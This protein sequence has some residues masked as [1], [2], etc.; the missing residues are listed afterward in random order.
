[1]KKKKGGGGARQDESDENKL[2][3]S[4]ATLILILQH[5][6]KVIMCCAWVGRETQY[7]RAVLQ[8]I[9][10]CFN[11]TAESEKVIIVFPQGSHSQEGRLYVF[12]PTW[13][14]F[15]E[16]APLH[17]ITNPER[18][19]GGR[20]LWSRWQTLSRKGRRASRR[21]RKVRGDSQL[22][23]TNRRNICKGIFPLLGTD[24]VIFTLFGFVPFEDCKK[25]GSDESSQP[26]K[27]FQ[28]GKQRDP[29]ET[30][31]ITWVL[32]MPVKKMSWTKLWIASLMTFSI[33]TWT[34]SSCDWQ[35]I[36][37]TRGPFHLS[38]EKG[39][40]AGGIM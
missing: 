20:Y 24:Q 10:S 23:R 38:P 9:F 29:M 33:S 40:L 18:R 22:V 37:R 15:P 25:R 4:F 11:L 19:S 26:V 31:L 14:C 39:Q 6:G 16:T 35:H 17:K 8:V 7:L 13:R 2:I 34:P 3:V 32:F 5:A 28:G 1:M 36:A 27:T 30:N 21:R 12:R